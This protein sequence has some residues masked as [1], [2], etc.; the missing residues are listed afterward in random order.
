MNRKDFE[1]SALKA[2]QL[3]IKIE[4]AQAALKEEIEKL[5]THYD[6]HPQH[7]EIEVSLKDVDG[8]KK[9]MVSKAERMCSLVYDVDKLQ[10]NLGNDL[11][12]E[13]VNKTYTVTDINA[14]IELMKAHRIKPSEFRPLINVK[15]EANKEAIKQL[16][17]LGEI[18]M[19]ALKGAYTAT[20][21]KVINIKEVK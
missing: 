13:V 6:T 4:K 12:F 19:K 2:Y 16:Y 5:K 1:Q 7:K 15:I 21:S 9:L 8:D 14:L 20:I 18:K 10:K 17:S 3:K 11:F